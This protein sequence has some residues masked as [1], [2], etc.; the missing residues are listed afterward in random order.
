MTEDGDI[1]YLFGDLQVSAAGTG[2]KESCLQKY[3]I[4]SGFI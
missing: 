4:Y 3:Y 1:I 2:G